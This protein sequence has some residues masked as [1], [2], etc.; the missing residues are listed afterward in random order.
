MTNPVSR[1]EDFVPIVDLSPWYSPLDADR[2]ELAARIERNCS[3]SGFFVVEGHRVP[4]GTVRRML[5]AVEWF[6]ALPAETKAALVGDPADPLQRGYIPLPRRENGLIEPDRHEVFLYN[7]FGEPG[8]TIPSDADQRLLLPNRMPDS[9]EFIAAVREYYRA[10]E[11]LALDIMRLF[12]RALRLPVGWFDDK[13]DNHT[14]SIAMNHYP[15]LPELKEPEALR[16][17]AHSDWGTMTILYQDERSGLQVFDPDGR[18]RDVPPRPRT[19][20]VN[21]GELMTRWTNNRW[22]GTVHRVV[23][24]PGSTNHAR[25]SIPFFHQPNYDAMI[26]CIPTCIDDATAPSYPPISAYDYFFQKARKARI[27]RLARK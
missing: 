2:N 3:S 13:F 25:Y 8:I 24:P 7:R 27:A 11:S 18:W 20:V 19:F 10:M 17:A 15:A 26:E 14:T 5:S 22:S 9:A 21:I 23:A 4:D 12:A 1:S 6:F 16:K